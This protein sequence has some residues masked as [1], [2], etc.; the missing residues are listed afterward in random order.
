MIP[1]F[2]QW[3]DYTIHYKQNLSRMNRISKEKNNRLNDNKNENTDNNSTFINNKHNTNDDNK[4]NY[5]KKNSKFINLLKE[6]SEVELYSSITD[7]INKNYL[8]VIISQANYG[9]D[10]ISNRFPNIVIFSAGGEG[11]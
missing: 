3:S 4:N 6:K 2:V 11:M 5:K 7:K 10:F 1:L 9:L 8:Y